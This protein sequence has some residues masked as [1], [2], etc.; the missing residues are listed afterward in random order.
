MS[1]IVPAWRVWVVRHWRSYIASSVT[2]CVC[3]GVAFFAFAGARRTESA[4]PRFLDH[5]D[6][7]TLSIST[8]GNYDEATNAKIAA[9]PGVASS[10]TYVGI[11]LS[12][13]VDGKPDRSEA[14]EITGTFDGRYFDQDR[15]TPTRGRLADPMRDDEI[16]LNE[17]GA[18]RFG[19]D[20]GQV[21][22]LGALSVEQFSDPAVFDTALPP[23]KRI[24]VTVVGIGLFPDEVVQDD[25]D[26]TPRLLIT[27]ALS[28]QNVATYGLQG[29]VLAEGE[30]AIPAVL[31]ELA[32]I[33]PITKVE[34]RAIS[35]DKANA[36]TAI[37]PLTLVLLLFGAIA[38]VV[39]VLLSCLA[40][41]SAARATR[42]GL[43]LFVTFGATRRGAVTMSL[44][45][46]V[47]AVGVGVIGAI[48][49]AII[50]SPAMPIG[51]V[52]R[53]EAAPGID[54]DLTVL[55]F[56]GVAAALVL[57]AWSA[58]AAFRELRGSSA[59]R[60][61]AGGLS[62]APL[63][64]AVAGLRPEAATGIRFALGGTSRL[65]ARSAI[66]AAVTATTAL[67]AAVTFALSLDRMLETPALFGWTADATVLSGSGYDN[68]DE[69]ELQTIL[70]S[71]P[72]IDGW[73]GAYFGADKIGTVDVPLIGMRPD[74][75]VVPPLL[76]GRFIRDDSEIVLGPRTAA[77]LTAEIG[78][79]LVLGATG[80]S[81][82]VT[83]VGTA[84]LPTIGKIHAA[85]TSLGRGAIV[86]PALVPG[87]DT[88]ILGQ[89]AG[90]LLGPNAVF[91]R[92]ADGVSIEAELAHLRDT[93]A[94]LA[95]F[96]GLD[97][98]PFQRPAEI[99]S[100]SEIGVAPIAL[101]L[102]L[103]AGAMV[104]LLI[105]LRQSVRARSKDLAVLAALGFTRRQRA[106]TMMWHSTVI[107][108]IG[109]VVGIP[110]GVIVGRQLWRAFAGRIDVVADTVTVWP[111]SAL[112][113]LLALVLANLVASAPA[114][115]ASRLN[116][117]TALRDQ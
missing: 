68:L 86:A 76:S 28:R 85:R 72:A 23:S 50:A 43:Q 3:F 17:F 35:E 69:Q 11:N 48:A 116:V 111:T 114:R 32:E 20:V 5:V 78:D 62:R 59:Y 109:L 22:E 104:C 1:A 16:V 74:S 49:L 52:R 26:R 83:V 47:C 65:V 54:V 38:A 29:L 19:Y 34:I 110:L 99:V 39:G 63:A 25:A 2:I 105:A 92:Y 18:D 30:A 33:V 9:I 64:G 14:W 80:S 44:M 57:V 100:S 81:R 7:S 94:P 41:S 97:V 82:V 77:A 84:V 101:A 70:R 58:I 40:L 10:R 15:F 21:L 4:Y 107:V 61:T 98:L 113:A 102:G 56:G 45:T 12:V 42:D 24:K 36:D 51:P 8:A 27:P 96:A 75:T 66:L 93:T 31:A 13:L 89:P 73:S 46:A 37:E 67:L 91:I 88:D 53:V 71:D 60:A 95:G 55:V 106:A 115:A 112:I 79:R 108:A 87:S 117:A 90:R 103:T 6:A